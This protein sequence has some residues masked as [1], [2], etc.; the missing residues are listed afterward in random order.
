MD[1]IRKARADG[2]SA[3]QLR[4]LNCGAAALKA[5]GVTAGAIGALKLL[6]VTINPF[7]AAIAIASA[8]IIGFGQAAAE[9]TNSLNATLS[10]RF[11]RTTIQFKKA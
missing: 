2:I 7:V 4:Q 5:A 11:K 8:A 9:S 1:S 3:A 6:S 10:D